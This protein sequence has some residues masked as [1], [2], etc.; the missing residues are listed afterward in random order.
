MAYYSVKR[1]FGAIG[2]WKMFSA[3]YRMLQQGILKGTKE[4]RDK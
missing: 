3:S 4:Q 2:G 1:W